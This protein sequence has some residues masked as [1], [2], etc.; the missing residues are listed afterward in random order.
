PHGRTRLLPPPV[1]LSRASPETDADEEPMQRDVESPLGLEHILHTPAELVGPGSLLE[2]TLK[3]ARSPASRPPE[4]LTPAYDELARLGSSRGC[5]T[6]L[7]GTGGDE[8]L[9]PPPAYAADRVLSLDSLALAQ[10]CRAWA[11]Y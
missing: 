9:L 11:G 2:A 4:L 8:W 5:T 6:I 10:L 7:D 1:R 3:L